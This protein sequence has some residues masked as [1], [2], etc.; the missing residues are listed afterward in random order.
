[1]STEIFGRGNHEMSKSLQ[2][3]VPRQTEAA[4]MSEMR[5]TKWVDLLKLVRE[6][7]ATVNGV[8]LK[9]SARLTLWTLAMHAN[10]ETDT[11]RVGLG[12]MM[13]NV[14]CSHN[15]LDSALWDLKLAGLISRKRQHENPE[16]QTGKAATRILNRELLEKAAARGKAENEAGKRRRN[17]KVV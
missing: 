8:R 11:A 6:C 3:N 15:T 4:A 16:T 17:S 5:Q 10:G 7:P 9:A 13:R 1:M 2:S 14:G 12:T